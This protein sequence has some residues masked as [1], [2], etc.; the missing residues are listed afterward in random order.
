[1]PHH[2]GAMKTIMDRSGAGRCVLTF[3]IAWIWIQWL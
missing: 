3:S 2:I 1:L